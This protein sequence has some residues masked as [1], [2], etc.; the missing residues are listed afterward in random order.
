MSDLERSRD[1][2]P[3]VGPAA[4]GLAVFAALMWAAWLGWD[5]EYHVVDGVE[6]GPYRTWQVLGC[7]ASVAVGAVLAQAWARTR[8]G[9]VLAV[10]GAVGLAVPWAVHAASTDDSGLWFVGLVLLLA[11]AVL[12]LAL[13]LTVAAA[14]RTRLARRD[15]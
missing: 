7:G 15:T 6:Q 5:D 11:G 2:R 1:T 14:V 13:L 12:G 10:A 4:L 8:G 9:V 3:R